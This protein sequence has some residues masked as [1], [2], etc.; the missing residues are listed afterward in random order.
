MDVAKLKRS[1]EG[2]SAVELEQTIVSS[3]YSFTDFNIV[4]NFVNNPVTGAG[5]K[6]NTAAV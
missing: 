5:N 1:S 4:N 6:T 3:L 2:L